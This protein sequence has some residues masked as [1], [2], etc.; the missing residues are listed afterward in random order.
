MANITVLGI[1]LAKN[2]FQLH[3]IDNQGTKVL[4]KR[5][6]RDKFL[7]TVA[8]IPACKIGIEACGASHHWYREL[9]KL[10]HDVGM[11]APQFV[12]PYVKSNKNDANDAEAIAEARSRPSMRYVPPKSI[13]QQDIQSIHRMRSGKVKAR[14]ALANQIRGLLVEYGIVIRQGIH[15]IG[16]KLPEILED[17]DNSLTFLMRTEL[18]GLYEDLKELDKRIEHYEIT[19]MEFAREDERCKK[20]M[21][22]E[23]IGM[24]SATALVASVGNGSAFKNG[25]EMAAFMGLVPR[26]SA[27]GNK[28]KL[29]GISKGGDVYLRTLL[30]HGGR[31]VVYSASRRED[32]LGK[33]VNEKVSRSN[34]NK[35]AVAVANRNLRIAWSI[36]TRGEDYDARVW[37]GKRIGQNV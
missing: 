5:V 20:L 16:K 36:L 29:L 31:S 25:R 32:A 21:K 34:K 24:L 2:I 35:T 12:K 4:T 17:A 6:S 33:W 14:T 18:N 26:H 10:G 7:S 15:N 19:L 28:T 1:D 8:N 22:I 37:A 11:I 30:V 3:G 27:S 13:E 23:G 9:V